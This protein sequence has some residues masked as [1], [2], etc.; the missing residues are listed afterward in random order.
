MEKNQR[1]SLSVLLMTVFVFTG[2]V[3]LW[4]QFAGGSGTEADPWQIATAEHL[5]NVRG[6]TG[7]THNDKYFI[8]T[9]NI[10]LGLAPW[11]EGEGWVP[12]GE[13]TSQFYGKYDGNNYVIEGLYI[14]RPTRSDQGLFGNINN[15]EIKNLGVVYALVTANLHVGVLAGYSHHNSRVSFCFAEG[16]VTGVEKV[17][18][19]IG[20]NYQYSNINQC[21]SRGNVSGNEYIGGLV[22][23]NGRYS[24]VTDCFTIGTVSGNRR[25]GGLLGGNID[26]STTTNCFS[27]GKVISS[28]WSQGFGIIGY[29][30]ANISNVFWDMETSAMVYGVQSE[31]ENVKGKAS[32]E[33]MQQDTFTEWDFTEIWNIYEDNQSYPFLR[34][35]Y[36]PPKRLNIAEDNN[37]LIISWNASPD[38]RLSGYNVYR[39]GVRLNEELIEQNEYFDT[40]VS[41]DG[42]YSYYVVAVNEGLETQPSNNTV[43]VDMFFEGGTGQSTS[44][45]LIS[46]HQHLDNIKNHLNNMFV[47]F[48]LINDIDLTEEFLETGAYYND[49]EGWIPIA[50]DDTKTFRGTFNGGDNIIKGLF[51]D[52]NTGRSGLFGMVQSAVIRNIGLV[53]VNI[54]AAGS[55]GGLI[56]NGANSIITDSFVIGNI[57]ASDRFSG[58]LAGNLWESSISRSYSK[59][60]VSCEGDYT[61]GLV[62]SVAKVNIQDSYS[63]CNVSGRRYVAGLVG[64]GSESNC[65]NCYS[66]G[67]VEGDNTASSGLVGPGF[68][69]VTNSYWNTETSGKETSDGGEGRTTEEMTYPHSVNT[70][71]D[72]D[73]DTVWCADE[74]FRENDG[75]PYL[76]EGSLSVEDNHNSAPL[77]KL[78]N[79][80]NPFNPETT[81][82]F[83]IPEQSNVQLVIYNIKGQ[84][85][86]TLINELKEAGEQKI[87]WN[88]TDDKG[89]NVSSGVY[90]YRLKTNQSDHLNKM[91]LIK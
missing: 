16:Q 23:L 82:Y 15:A 83:T 60:Q 44:P 18:I 29:N 64:H 1:R 33:M 91:L 52:R 51:M 3:G 21:Y 76:R 14:N 27:S 10:D 12:I 43:S 86:K 4:A 72:W 11:N 79:Y 85:I 81:I 40:D 32:N 58:G 47:S 7:T 68:E 19:L 71:V 34:A 8:Q 66:I 30:D 48:L 24:N 88:G 37:E 67:S 55:V 90:F 13:A 70:Y 50:K 53:D 80:P 41:E 31:N 59:G 22:G 65:I 49:G 74:D 26:S 75:Y 69:T 5:D 9:A 62:G 20:N 46:K 42:I 38:D 73:F 28:L 39:N 61:G 54:S 78:Y 87:V 36:S 35:F 63:F 57:K 56:G 84:H 45:Y 25:L 89:R 77:S 2:T 6:Y 17:G